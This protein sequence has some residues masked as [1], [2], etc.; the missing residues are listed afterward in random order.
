M[1]LLYLLRSLRRNPK[2]RS[3]SR[4]RHGRHRWSPVRCK[5]S[6]TRQMLLTTSVSLALGPVA[7]KL[8]DRPA[9]SCVTHASPAGWMSRSATSQL[10]QKP[11]L[12][13]TVLPPGKSS[14]QTAQVIV[15]Q[16]LT[17]SSPADSPQ[18]PHTPAK[19]PVGL[20][21]PQP[22]QHSNCSAQRLPEAALEAHQV[23][24]ITLTCRRGLGGRFPGP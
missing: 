19:A 14:S 1:Q 2:A 5:V 22:A 18:P 4:A 7:A 9:S 23:G 20:L 15:C 3:I 16:G 21:D 8:G 13:S 6:A 24:S 10:Q 11:N 17:C 12:A